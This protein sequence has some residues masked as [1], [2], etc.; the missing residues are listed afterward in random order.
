MRPYHR[1]RQ[2]GAKVERRGPG[3]AGASGYSAGMKTVWTLACGLSLALASPAWA[4]LQSLGLYE[5]GAVY[6]DEAQA[7]VKD[8]AH[9]KVW[10][11]TDYTSPQ[12]HS[13]G[14]LYQSSRAWIDIDC[15]SRQARV[16]HLTLF[17]KPGQSGARIEREGLLHEWLPIVPDS[18]MAR[19]AYRLC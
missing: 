10:T 17:A 19:L 4:R 3:G 14:A 13:S 9:R 16:M 5:H 7:P 2:Q 15:Q 18:P 12:R 6:I 8:G 1:H 11:V